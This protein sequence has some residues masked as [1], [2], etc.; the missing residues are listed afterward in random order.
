M[1]FNPGSYNYL[2]LS[3]LRE[4]GPVV[5]FTNPFPE[6]EKIV[7]GT[8]NAHTV[9]PSESTSACS[10]TVSVAFSCLSGG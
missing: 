5:L 4:R 9:H 3:A 6:N 1:S 8:G 2:P 7:A 10:I